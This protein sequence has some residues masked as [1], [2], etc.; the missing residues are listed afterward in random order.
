MCQIE[1]IFAQIH[2][3][4]FCCYNFYLFDS[5]SFSLLSFLPFL[6]V[7]SLFPLV[8]ACVSFPLSYCNIIYHMIFIKILK[9][10]NPIRRIVIKSLLALILIIKMKKWGRKRMKNLEVKLWGGSLEFGGHI[11]FVDQLENFEPTVEFLFVET[12]N[13]P[14]IESM[15]SM[16]VNSCLEYFPIIPSS[17]MKNSHHTTISD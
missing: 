7:H 4:F 6:T 12:K 14:L 11:F 2:S 17:A 9:G 8:R 15:V 16:K 10:W 1:S 13:E 5:L 3:S